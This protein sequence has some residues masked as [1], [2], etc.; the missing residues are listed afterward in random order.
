MRPYRN[1]GSGLGVPFD[2][3]AQGM[4]SHGLA[5]AVYPQTPVSKI[6]CILCRLPQPSS[7]CLATWRASIQ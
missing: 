3:I 4:L 1:A 5:E 7:H 6:V 2:Q